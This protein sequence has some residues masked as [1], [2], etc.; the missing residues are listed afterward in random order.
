MHLT[1]GAGPQGLQQAGSFSDWNEQPHKG[2]LKGTACFK[3]LF[4]VKVPNVAARDYLLCRDIVESWRLEETMMSH[5]LR[6]FLKT[7]DARYRH[8]H[9][10]DLCL[11]RIAWFY[12]W[13]WVLW[14]VSKQDTKWLPTNHKCFPIMINSALKYVSENIWDNE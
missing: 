3:P 6:M 1:L 12:S 10:I 14:A 11:I 5:C 7:F 9:N 4:P 2:Q 8:W 13:I